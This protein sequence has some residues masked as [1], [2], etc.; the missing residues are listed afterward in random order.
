MTSCATAISSKA[1]PSTGYAIR[2]KICK[3]GAHTVTIEG[4]WSTAKNAIKG[5]FHSVSQKYLQDYPDEYAF[6]Y[7]HQDDV[8]PMDLVLLSKV[9]LAHLAEQPLST[10]LQSRE[11]LQTELPSV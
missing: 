10:N 5:V 1:R 3:Q 7:N 2:G 11:K 9:S 8:E 6:H 4:R